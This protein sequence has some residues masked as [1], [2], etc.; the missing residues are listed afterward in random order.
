MSELTWIEIIYWGSTII[1][2]TLFI[3]RTIM[4]LV[5]GGLGHDDFDTH[6]DGDIPMDQ[7]IPFDSD[8]TDTSADS[9]FSFRLLSMQGL[10]AFFMMFGLVGL[11]L[12]KAD[13]A[14]GIT[15]LGG[16]SAGL[17]AVW[18]I[19][20]LFAQMKHLRSDGT[21]NIHNA[22]GQSGSVYLIIPAKG[23]GQVQ[24]SVQGALKILDA[25]ST[26]GRRIETGEKIRV[27]G[28]IDNNT[29]VV[30]KI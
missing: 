11:A 19:S 15:I 21:L 13:L 17:F 6:I 30:E 1:G 9:D 18:V 7:D 23:T 25:I 12:T 24:V 10:T 8:H 14:I 29:L 2:G 5:G 27:T 26:N 16:G 4:L 22:I 3:L 28:T 20:L